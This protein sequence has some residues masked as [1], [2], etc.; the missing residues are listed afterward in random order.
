MVLN[1]KP[2]LKGDPEGRI[3]SFAKVRGRKKSVLALAEQ[4]ERYVRNAGEQTV[5]IAHADCAED[6]EE[7]IALLRG[8]KNPPGEIMTVMYEPVTGSHVGPGTVALFF[9][10]DESFRGQTDS[11]LDSVARRADE[12]RDALRERL[13]K[14]A[15]GGRKR[16]ARSP[17]RRAK[18]AT[19]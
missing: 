10:G 3:V 2:L 11:L 16:S 9:F 12:G 14:T 7:L 5:G 1:I 13:A 6:A 18:G 17:G 4:Y 8:G 19:R 15:D